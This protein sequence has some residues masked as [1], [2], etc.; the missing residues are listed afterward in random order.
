MKPKKE[1]MPRKYKG[2]SPMSPY[3]AFIDY[4]HAENQ[5]EADTAHAVKTNR[6]IKDVDREYRKT[7]KILEVSGD[8]MNRAKHGK[9]A[10]KDWDVAKDIWDASAEDEAAKRKK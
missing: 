6:S 2:Q 4:W 3:D 10:K 7:G 5:R 9:P 8:A 1:Q